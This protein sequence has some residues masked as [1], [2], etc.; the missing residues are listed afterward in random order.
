MQLES[1]SSG[2][3]GTSPQKPTK[4]GGGADSGK[5]EAGEAPE[6]YFE[7]EMT[8][9]CKV[10]KNVELMASKTYVRGIILILVYFDGQFYCTMGEG[11][12]DQVSFIFFFSVFFLCFF[13]SVLLVL[14]LCAPFSC[15]LSLSHFFFLLF[16]FAVSFFLFHI[17]SGFLVSSSPPAHSHFST[18]PSLTCPNEVV[19]V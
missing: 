17:Y 4:I 6:E 13:F 10:Y 7:L 3:S 8:D 16:N 18:L 15:L 19:D 9:A 11:Q 1:L 14:V 5:M 2:G 12:G